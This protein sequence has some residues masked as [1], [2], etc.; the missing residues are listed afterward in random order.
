MILNNHNN[1]FLR[2]KFIFLISA[3]ASIVFLFGCGGVSK[4]EAE[5]FGDPSTDTRGGIVVTTTHLYDLA[6]R[7]TNGRF[8]ITPLMG[9]GVDPHIYKPSSRDILALSKASL[10]IY[11][12]MM[13]EGRLSE[14][15]AHGKQKGISIYNATSSLADT[16]IISTNKNNSSQLHPDPHVW[17]DPKIWAFIVKEFTNKITEY[18]PSEKE[19]FKKNAKVFLEEIK[20]IEQWG[21]NEIKKIP[22]EQRTIVTSHD[23]FQ[24][25]GR[26]MGLKV[27]ALQGISTTAEAGLGDRANL[28]DLIRKYKIPAIFIESSVN[29][30]AI[31]EIAKECNVVVGGELFSDALGSKEEFAIGPN[32]TQYR[33]NTWEGMMVH[34]INTIVK[35]LSRKR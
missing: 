19:V 21:L 6:T 35:A 17:F 14:A 11:H 31:E 32:G 27:V 25:F 9:P 20:K 2:P 30:S 8:S 29:P 7:I 28:V 5:D 12:G 4:D 16:Q 34:N 3:Y 23:A 10:V 15:L 22:S 18:A 13:L 33:A 24:Y 26:S 1:S